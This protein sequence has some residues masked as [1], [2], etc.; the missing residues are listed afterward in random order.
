[1]LQVLLHLLSMYLN[2][3]HNNRTNTNTATLLSTTYNNLQ[4]SPKIIHAQEVAQEV[5]ALQEHASG[6]KRVK[7]HFIRKKFQ[8]QEDQNPIR[9]KPQEAARSYESYRKPQITAR[10]L[11]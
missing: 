5:L 10:S 9:K 2:F 4:Y 6:E 7:L 3:F 8:M 11:Q 1:M